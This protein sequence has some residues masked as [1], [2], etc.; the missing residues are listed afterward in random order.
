MKL[1]SYDESGRWRAGVLIDD[2]VVDA[3][4]AAE[5]AALADAGRFGSV[6]S[7]IANGRADL[8]DLAAAAEGLATAGRRRGDVR[9]GPPVPDAEKILCIGLNYLDHQQESA[10]DVPIAEQLPTVPM[11]FNKFTPALIGDGAPIEPPAATRQLDFEAE[12]AVVL[13]RTARNVPA[14]DAMDYVAGYS[15]FNDVSARDLQLR[16]PQWAIGKGFDTSGPMGPALV[17]RDEIPDPQQ[18]TVTGRL[19]GEIMQR[20]ST[21]LMIFSI[22]QLIEYISQAIT[23][24]P[25]DIIAT[26][27]PSGVGFTRTPPV[28]LQ[29]GDTFEVEIDG[30]GT[31]SNQV[32]APRSR[33][34]S[35]LEPVPAGEPLNAESPA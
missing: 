13:G 23:L 20:S 4:D 8:A 14:G 7:I 25:G 10:S 3:R 21:S 16:S 5:R 9:L 11:V 27:T 19:N 18:L 31:L 30:I 26:G 24:V 17:T 1:V 12:L 35:S 15:A 2:R 32:I 33:F 34:L 6:R 28:Y 22:A 29:P